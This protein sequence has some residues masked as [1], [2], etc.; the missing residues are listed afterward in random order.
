MY[1]QGVVFWHTSGICGLT[2]AL[3]HAHT[4]PVTKFFGSLEHS[5]PACFMYH[6]VPAC[7]QQEISATSDSTH[8]M[9]YSLTP[10]CPVQQPF[11]ALSTPNMTMLASAELTCSL[12]C[13]GFGQPAMAAMAT[14][15]CMCGLMSPC[16]HT[17]ERRCLSPAPLSG[18]PG[19][20]LWAARS[21]EMPMCPPMSGALLLRYVLQWLD[22]H[23]G[24]TVVHI[25]LQL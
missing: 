1:W 16:R 23:T 15:S 20:A 8:V 17:M 11:H 9:L 21:L 6:H 19:P 22:T 3:Q 10:P 14:K 13:R 7:L 5:L 24:M 18:A 4:S 12:Y 25:E 2:A